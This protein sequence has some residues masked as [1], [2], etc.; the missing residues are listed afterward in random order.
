MYPVRRSA[1]WELCNFR[2]ALP[3]LEHDE[4]V[5]RR[6]YHGQRA[7][8]PV[9]GTQ[10]IRGFDRRGSKARAAWFIA[11]L[12]K[13]GCRAL[14]P[15]FWLRMFGSTT[16]AGGMEQPSAGILLRDRRAGA[17]AERLPTL[18]LRFS[19][20]PPS[21]GDK[22][23][24]NASSAKITL[25]RWPDHGLAD[26]AGEIPTVDCEFELSG[27]LPLAGNQASRLVAN[28]IREFR[29]PRQPRQEGGAA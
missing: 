6:V 16:P 22:L 3:G 21:T 12:A 13:P 8:Q 26:D 28:L 17:A 4:N 15:F 10:A 25:S 23:L 27:T 20:L 18:S 5:V 24:A 9:R 2:A 11:M 19:F 14:W 29:Q 7:R 1:A